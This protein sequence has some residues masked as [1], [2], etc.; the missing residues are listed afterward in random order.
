M[1]THGRVR[2]TRFTD[3]IGHVQH[4]II[5]R[6]G[7]AREDSSD[8]VTSETGHRACRDR[9]NSSDFGFVAGGHGGSD[10]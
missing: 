6:I 1:I 5:N 10:G 3:N 4:G 7:H 2:I 9:H 8:R